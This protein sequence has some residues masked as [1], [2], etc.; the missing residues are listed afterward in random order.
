M[1]SVEALIKRIGQKLIISRV[2]ESDDT[3]AY[4]TIGTAWGLRQNYRK[5]HVTEIDNVQGRGFVVYLWDEADIDYGD[6]VRYRDEPYKVDEI[7]LLDYGIN[8]YKKV[9]LIEYRD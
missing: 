3:T 4:G 8:Q 7:T 5:D 9:T 1:K 2:I 6:R